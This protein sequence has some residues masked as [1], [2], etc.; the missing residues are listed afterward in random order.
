MIKVYANVVG[1]FFFDTRK[2]IRNPIAINNHL[3]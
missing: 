3:L 1:F 2:D